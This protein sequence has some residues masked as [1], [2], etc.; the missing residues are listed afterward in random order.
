MKRM[1]RLALGGTAL[2]AL[3]GCVSAPLG[4]TVP[5]WPGQGKSLAAFH[6]DEDYCDSY[7]YDRVSGRVKAANDRGTRN[8]IIGTAL[9]VGLGAAVGDTKGAIVGGTAGA[10]IGA[11]S[12]AGGEQ[13]RVQRAYNIAYAQCMDSRGNR[14]PGAGPP[15]RYR[16]GPPPPPDYRRGDYPPPPP[17][18][19]PPPPDDY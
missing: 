6:A 5:V 12:G 1:M 13:H 19:P 18:P 8:A 2:L 14:V 4:P 15:P 9:G 7:A 17:G 10:A 3:G 11:N 16:N